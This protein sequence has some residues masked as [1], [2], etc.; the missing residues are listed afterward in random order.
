MIDLALQHETAELLSQNFKADTIEAIG[1]IIFRSFDCHKLAGKSSH[2]TLSPKKCAVI[3][4]DYCNAEKKLFDLIQLLIQLDESTINGKLVTVNGLE[5]Y[6]NKLTQTGIYYDFRKRKVLRSKKELTDLLNWGSLKDG[7]E[8]TLTIFSIDIVN[9]SKLVI[10]HGSNT[11]EKVYFQLKGF[12][13]KKLYEY[14]GRLWNFAGDGGLA[15]FAF[16]NQVTR[17]VL[18]ALDIQYSLP[19]FNINP[20]IKLKDSITLRIGIDTGKVKFFNETGNIVSDVIN[21]AAHLEKYATEPGRI[22]IS[23][24]VIKQLD[25]KIAR[26]FPAKTLFEEKPVFSTTEIMI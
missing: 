20:S 24:S 16:K 15:A 6:L 9:N 11:M 22:S 2:I 7:K 13:A 26:L 4:V 23:E 10:K 19:L 17:G 8:Y 12:L 1:K 3:L 25:K 21:F 5:V 14:D 18:C